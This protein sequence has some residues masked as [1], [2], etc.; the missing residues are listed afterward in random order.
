MTINN[1]VSLYNIYDTETIT[2]EE[3]NKIYI[4]Q[5]LLEEAQSIS[6]NSQYTGLIYNDQVVGI[7]ESNINTL[8]T[9]FGSDFVQY[10]DIYIATNDAESYMQEVE[11][12]VMSNLN[13]TES[14]SVNDSVEIGSVLSPELYSLLSIGEN[15]ANNS[16]FISVNDIINLHISL[17][18]TG[19]LSNTQTEDAIES[20]EENTEVSSSTSQSASMSGTTETSSSSSSSTSSDTEV[21]ELYAKLAKIEQQIADLKIEQNNSEDLDAK[22]LEHQ[23]ASLNNQAASITAE[24]ETLL[25]ETEG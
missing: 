9:L 16:T 7:N 10:Q 1:D 5:Q 15:Q 18:A 2:Q 14:I 17:N 23:I 12:Y 6:E 4:S 8:S 25:N 3:R 22:R 20:Y 24:I 13:T 21:Q 19:E 11:D